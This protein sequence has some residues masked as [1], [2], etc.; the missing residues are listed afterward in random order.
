MRRAAFAAGLAL[1][2]ACSSAHAQLGEPE[3]SAS[4]ADPA[5]APAPRL[6]PDPAPAPVPTPALAVDP[7]AEPAGSP[8]RLI[9]P[10]DPAF[11]A[12]GLAT[13]LTA[14]IGFPKAACHPGCVP[15]SN[16]LGIDD[17]S[18]GNYRPAAHTVANVLVATLVLAPLVIDAVDSRLHGWAE[19]SVVMIES[20]LLAQGMTQ[21]MKSAV[22]RTAPFVY[23]PAAAQSDLDSPDAFR[24]FT[25]GHSATAFSAATAYSVTFWRRHPTSPWRFVVL[26]LSHAMAA[27]VAALKVEAG[28]HYA[29]DVAAGALIGSAMGVLVPTLHAQW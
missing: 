19:D 23:N 10:Y 15:P 8:Y 11:V 21:V 28:Y 20:I 25:S 5:P 4:D 26:G 27:S 6:A 17:A 18:V 22:G 24:S 14:F 9:W 7:P 29:T 16:M 2:L 13:S 12:F 1:T 3:P